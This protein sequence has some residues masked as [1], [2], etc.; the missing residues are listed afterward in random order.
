VFGRRES[1]DWANREFDGSSSSKRQASERDDQERD[2]KGRNHEAVVVGRR[3]ETVEWL[4]LW[5]ECLTSSRQYEHR[6][7]GP[8]CSENR[9][10]ERRSREE[11]GEHGERGCATQAKGPDRFVAGAAYARGCSYHTNSAP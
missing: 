11:E 10:D 7:E 2:E 9:A 8:D 4:A 3:R 5:A 6:E 1:G